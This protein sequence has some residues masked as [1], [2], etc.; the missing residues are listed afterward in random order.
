MYFCHFSLSFSSIGCFD[1]HSP[2]LVLLVLV[3][4]LDTCGL[5]TVTLCFGQ[6]FTLSCPLA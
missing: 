1:V 5:L 6:G 4:S 3:M 2:L